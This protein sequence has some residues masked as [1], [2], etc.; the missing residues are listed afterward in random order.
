MRRSAPTISSARS[1]SRA[2]SLVAAFIGEPIMQANGVQIPPQVLLAAGARD[3]RP[4]GVL[5]IVDE[6]ITGFGRTGALVR[7]RTFGHRG[8]HH[9]D[10]E[11]HHGGYAAMGAV[12]TRADITDAC[13]CS[14]TFTPSAATPPPAPRPMP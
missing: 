5:L 8:R 10:G 3:L 12:V 11:V 13:R 1:S 7:Q 2:R 6:V 4:Y 9:D 14:A